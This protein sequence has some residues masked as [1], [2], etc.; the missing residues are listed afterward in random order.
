MK[1]HAPLWLATLVIGA[2]LGGCA[3]EPEPADTEAAKTEAAPKPGE[4]TANAGGTTT[5]YGSA[6]DHTQP[7]NN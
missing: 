3:K 4:I 5:Y 2:C 1:F 7:A 6:E